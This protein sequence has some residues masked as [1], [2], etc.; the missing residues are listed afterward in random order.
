MG[1]ATDNFFLCNLQFNLNFQA[2]H[3]GMSGPRSNIG[4]SKDSK[5]K[6]LDFKTEE[7]KQKDPNQKGWFRQV[8]FLT[9]KS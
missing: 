3:I 5:F 1:L 2:V 4:A 8:F 9:S 7:E 6:H